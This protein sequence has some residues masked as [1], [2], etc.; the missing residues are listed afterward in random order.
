MST[1]TESDIR[2]RVDEL[3]Q[4]IQEG[5]ILQAF[6]KFYADDIV[7]EEDGDARVGFEANREYEENFVS[8]IEEFR[9]AEVKSVAVDEENNVSFVEWHLD[10]TLEGV[11]DVEQNQVAVQRWSDGQ[12][13]N[14]KFYKLG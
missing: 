2:E 3:N 12:I 5:K 7:M 8:S 13:H 11:G 14:E 10:F 1:T 4:M 6:D 9:A